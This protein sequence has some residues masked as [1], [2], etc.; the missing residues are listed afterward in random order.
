MNTDIKNKKAIVYLGCSWVAGWMGDWIKDIYANVDFDKKYG[1]WEEG[2]IRDDYGKY[3]TV[4]WGHP[5]ML[6]RKYK[7]TVDVYNLGTSGSDNMAM[8]YKLILELPLLLAE[9][10]PENV[11]ILHSLTSPTRFSFLRYHPVR[12]GLHIDILKVA[13]NPGQ[14]KTFNRYEK[15]LWESYSKINFT[16]NDAPH[17]STLAMLNI[18]SVCKAN[19]FKYMMANSFYEDY[20]L[21]FE[22]EPHFGNLIDWSKSIHNDAPYDSFA[23]LLLQEDKTIPDDIDITDIFKKQYVGKELE[24]MSVCFHPNIHGHW[25]ISEHWEKHILKNHPEF[26]NG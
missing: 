21:L 22:T 6:H 16:Y 25:L 15:M 9:Y 17:L 20:R 13:L 19:G 1:I 3:G 24:Y 11:L 18:Q 8:Y 12:K 4:R 5:G 23:E 7:D 14:L 10:K 26:L 2:A